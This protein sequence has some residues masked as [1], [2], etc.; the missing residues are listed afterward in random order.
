MVEGVEN[1]LNYIA[2][3]NISNYLDTDYCSY[4]SLNEIKSFDIFK[5]WKSH[6]FT[7]LMLSKMAR[8]LLTPSKSTF[9]I[10]V[11]IL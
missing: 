9:S 1:I 3:S 2:C 7:F 8:D 11:N 4:P 10:A 6:E 5:W